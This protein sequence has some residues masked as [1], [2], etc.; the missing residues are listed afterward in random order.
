MTARRLEAL[1]E[2]FNEYENRQDIH[3]LIEH[4]RHI[5]AEPANQEPHEPLIEIYHQATSFLEDEMHRAEY[6]DDLLE[7]HRQLFIEMESHIPCD[8]RDSRFKFIIVIPVADRPQHLENCLASLLELCRRFRYGGISKQKYHKITALVADDSKDSVNRARNREILRRFEQQGVR[9]DYFGQPEQIQQLERLNQAERSALKPVIGDN[10]PNAFHHKGASITRNISYLRLN[11]PAGD[12]DR[13][14]IWFMDSDQAFQVNPESRPEGVYAI[15][16]FHRLN[17]LFSTTDTL[18]M[19]GKVVGDP[20]VSPAVMAGNFLEDLIGFLTDLAKLDRR[21]GCRFHSRETAQTDDASYHDMADLFGFRPKAEVFHYHCTLQGDHD[22]VRCFTDFS[23]KLN[24]FFDGE[25]PTRQTYY[26]HQAFASSIKPARTVYTGNYVLRSEALEYFIPFAT[27]KLRMAGPVL[28]RILKSELGHRFVSA[29]L[30]M[31][32]RRTLAETGQS[33]FRPGIDRDSEQIDMSGEFERQFFGDV[34]LF[35]VEALTGLGYPQQPL[36]EKR[37]R[38]TLRRVESSMLQKYDD[39]HLQI[40]AKLVRLKRLVDD[41]RNCW[42]QSP[43]CQHA[44]S[45]VQRFIRNMDY[46]FGEAS[47]GY[48]MIDSAQHR[49]KRRSEILEALLA[50]SQ[51]RTDWVETLTKM[52]HIK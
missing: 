50:L 1:T 41:Q 6:P 8:E 48:R 36:S 21:Q 4:W 32:H 12:D 37:V 20:P 5:E 13:T 25:H 26:T 11:R 19:T 51:T 7:R 44:L 42:R 34:M 29:N 33:E 9:T 43:D 23:A 14:L 17:R 27:L 28:G 46:N 35:T 39:K 15:N 40:V 47:P 24:R 16:Y 30:P 22:H 31:L 18:V 52:K 10:S 38:Q 3:P 2:F 45:N 49:E